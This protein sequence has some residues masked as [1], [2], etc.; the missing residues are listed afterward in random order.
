MHAKS[1]QSCPTLYDPMD[2]RSPGSSVHGD[3]PG[4]NTEVGCHALLK[5][6]FSTQ[7]ANPCLLRL[8]CMEG[9]FFTISTT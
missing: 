1:L 4:R 9:G 5:G 3:S 6:I 7:G 2:C 8:I